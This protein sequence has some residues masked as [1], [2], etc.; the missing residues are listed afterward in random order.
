MKLKKA[1]LSSLLV[2]ALVTTLGSYTSIFAEQVEEK[3]GQ[4]ANAV[5]LQSDTSVVTGAVVTASPIATTGAVVTASPI[6]ATGAVVTASPIVT[7]GTVVT[8]SPIVTTSPVITETPVPTKTPTPTIN[9]EYDLEVSYFDISEASP[10]MMGTKVILS[11]Q[12]ENGKG[13]YK[14]TYKVQTPAGNVETIL[15]DSSKNT[16]QYTFSAVGTYKFELKIEDGFS[17][18]T[19]T[20]TFQVTEKVLVF[21]K[22]V[23]SNSTMKLGE[24][25][26]ITAKAAPAKGS[27]Q[28]KVTVKTPANKTITVKKFSK[29]ATATYK[30]TKAGKY[31]VKVVVKDLTGTEITKTFTFKVTK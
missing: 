9:P 29:K 3:K 30:P 14:Y 11:G 8:A 7:T 22:C 28:Y 5:S 21:T 15:K 27:A 23:L 26:K 25:V 13:N 1:A 18:V 10:K 19:Q 24:S 2:A 31:T 4:A 16:T 12:G 6:T 20:K 17:V